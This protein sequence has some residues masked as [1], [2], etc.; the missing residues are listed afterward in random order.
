M[1]IRL[2]KFLLALALLPACWGVLKGF[3]KELVLND[4]FLLV[5]W[6]FLLGMICYGLLSL[7]WQ[8]PLRTY[9]FGHELAHALWVWFFRGKV[10]GFSVSLKGGHVKTTKTNFL[11]ALAPYFFPVYSILLILIYLL[12]RSFWPLT[13]YFKIAVFFIGMSWGFHVIMTFYAL[14]KD[15]QEVRETGVSFSIVLI[16]I[17]NTL[18]LGGMLSFAS[19]NVTIEVFLTGLLQEVKKVYLLSYSAIRSL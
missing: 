17:L 3:F 19:P 5:Q 6:P 12:L 2:I 13:P 4:S 8:Q 7:F 14:F 10:K 9:V 16:L 15:Q 1:G 18:F 11:I